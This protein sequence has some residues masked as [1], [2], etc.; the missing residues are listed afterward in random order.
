MSVM[1]TQAELAGTL[2]TLTAVIVL[3]SGLLSPA[4]TLAMATLV[5]LP[6]LTKESQLIVYGHIDTTASP[7]SGGLRFQVTGVLKGAS[8]NPEGTVLLCN[9]RPNTE[10]PDLSK[11]TG[12]AVLFLL[13]SRSKECFNLSHNYRSVVRIHGDQVDTVAIDGEPESQ[14]LD[15]FLGEIRSLALSAK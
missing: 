5:T 1:R 11:L 13:Q 7:S 10:W 9:S 3:C 12:D 2:G 4:V 8:S 6:E 15:R 14:P